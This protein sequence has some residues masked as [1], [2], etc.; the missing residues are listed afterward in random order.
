MEAEPH[1]LGLPGAEAV[2]HDP[3]PDAPGGA[4]LRHLLEEVLLG[5]EVEGEPGRER[6]DRHARAGH[7]LH[8]GDPVGHREGHLLDGARPGLGDVVAADVDRVVARHALGGEDDHVAHDAHRGPDGEDPLLLGDVLLEDVGLDGAREAVEIQSPRLGERHVHREQDP[9]GR[10]DRHRHRDPLEVDAL[11]QRRDVV[12]RVNGHAFASDLAERAGVVGVVAHQGRH[13]EVDGEPG[14]ALVDQIAEARVGVGAGAES[15]DLAHRPGPPPVH[16]GVGTARVGILA[17]QAD[18]LV[19][20]A[21]DVLGRVDALPRET[22][23]G[24]VVAPR[25][26]LALHELAQLGAFP[27]FPHPP[28]P[29]DRLSVVHR[30]SSFSTSRTARPAAAGP[31]GPGPCSLAPRARAG[32]PW[33]EG[34]RRIRPAGHRFR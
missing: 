12:E 5:D 29:L 22:G 14:L 3:G 21:G 31:V 17:G 32:R 7:L 16:G 18:V 24:P 6:V 26:R 1:R 8:V 15:G 34:R 9:R 13:V 11:E 28:D 20:R 19:R 23:R 25:L 4:E 10:V 2:P 27:G 30:A 33:R